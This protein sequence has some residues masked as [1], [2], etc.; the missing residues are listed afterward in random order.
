MPIQ[1]TMHI[2]NL[3][4]LFSYFHQLFQVKKN[5]C[6]KNKIL[7]EICTKIPIYVLSRLT[8]HTKNPV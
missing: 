6:I 1:Y 2:L 7:R 3:Q 4:T 8:K 5:I